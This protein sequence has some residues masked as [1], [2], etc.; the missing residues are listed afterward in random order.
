MTKWPD[1]ERLLIARYLAGLSLRHPTSCASYRQVLNSFQDVAECHA[2]LRKD[3]LVAWLRTLSEHWMATTLLNRARI[4]ERFLEYLLKTGAIASNPVADL[5]TACN[6]KR[7]QPV[8][9]ALAS[10][11]PEQALADLRQP[12]PFGSSLGGIMAE[13]VA[14]MRNRGYKY[15]SQSVWFL[16]FDRFL[17]LNPA[18]QDESIEVMLAAPIQCAPKARNTSGGRFHPD[19]CR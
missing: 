3:V 13:H 5:C 18:L 9:R 4:I 7:C 12:K 8:W 16:R 15:T 10:H 14:L 6:I 11:D 19:N 1:P 2:E 17:Q